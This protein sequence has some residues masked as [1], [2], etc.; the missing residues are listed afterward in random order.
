MSVYVSVWGIGRTPWK[1]SFRFKVRVRATVGARVMARVSK[2]PHQ[3]VSGRS[4]CMIGVHGWLTVGVCH[5]CTWY[6]A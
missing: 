2:A 3:L 6:I 1:G 5:I 4:L